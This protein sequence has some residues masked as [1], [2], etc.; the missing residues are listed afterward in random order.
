MPS[1]QSVSILQALFRADS[2]LKSWRSVN[3]QH[4]GFGAAW[5]EPAMRGGALKI[6]TVAGFKPVLGF[7]HR[8]MQFPLQDVQKLLALVGV[9][10]TA[11]SPRGDAKQVRLHYGIPPSQQFHADS[12]AGFEHF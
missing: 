3:P 10:F 5:V 4:P 9:G 7:R 6:K 12:R 8:N 11:A 1:H 2:D